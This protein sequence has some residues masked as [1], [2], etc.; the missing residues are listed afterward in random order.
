MIA[1]IFLVQAH[2]VW[3]DELDHLSFGFKGVQQ[4]CRSPER[5]NSRSEWIRSA[6]EW[7][8]LVENPELRRSLPQESPSIEYVMNIHVIALE[9]LDE[10]L[11]HAVALG[12]SCRR[13]PAD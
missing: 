8:L 11:C 6:L 9:R 1:R 2:Q 12:A 7:G 5:I 13:K 10:G 3:H 4:V